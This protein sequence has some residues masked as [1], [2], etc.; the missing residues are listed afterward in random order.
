MK[1]H[2]ASAAEKEFPIDKIYNVIISW[3]EKNKQINPFHIHAVRQKI[4][5]NKEG[6]K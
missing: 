4:K 6:G 5:S 2:Q 3:I 1:V